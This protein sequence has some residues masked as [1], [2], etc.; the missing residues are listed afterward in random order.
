M[1]RL[2]ALFLFF[3]IHPEVTNQQMTNIFHKHSFVKHTSPK[4]MMVLRT[5]F[6]MGI[7]Q[8]ASFWFID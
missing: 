3:N 5:I 2:N 1:S 8:K 4:Q 6:I 7:N